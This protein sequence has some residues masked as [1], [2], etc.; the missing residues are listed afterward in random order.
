MSKQTSPK[1]HWRTLPL[2]LYVRLTLLLLAGLVVAQGV[3]LW[4]QWDE[5]TVVV[6]QARGLNFA[7]QIARII[8][9]LEAA[10]PDQRTTTLPALQDNELS[11][12]LIGPSQVSTISPRGA[13]GRLVA[14]R[15]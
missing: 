11:A 15:L 1:A 2:S 14:Q 10:R 4:L 12:V 7:D 9:V 13:I 5:R 8:R 6:T 3:S